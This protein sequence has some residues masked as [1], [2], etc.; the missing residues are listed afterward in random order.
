VARLNQTFNLIAD[1]TF[2]PRPN[3]KV[4]AGPSGLH[5][6]YRR[7]GLNVLC[8]EIRVPPT[9]WAVAPRQISIALTNACDLACSYCYAPKH[10]AALDVV[11]L[12]SWLRELDASGCLA[13]GFGGGEPTLH[14]HFIE[15]CQY[16][17]QHTAL[18]VTFTTHAHRIDEALADRLRESVHFVRVSMDGV[19]A[20]YELLRGRSFATLRTRFKIIQTFARFGINFVVNAATIRDLD[21]AIR[22]ATDV[23]ASEFLLLPEQPVHGQGGID[24]VTLRNLHEWVSKYRGEVPLTISE[25]GSEGMPIV[26]ASADGTGLR[27]YA[28]IDADSILRRSS[29]S[30]RGVRIGPGGVIGALHLLRA[31]EE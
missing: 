28:H 16:V 5:L 17:A 30:S 29:Y 13:V 18:A 8:D 1:T 2:A 11:P 22:M 26:P 23:G 10:R 25:A 31:Q 15:L 6:F 21:T 20:N 9:L 12:A 4:R 19:G 3:L 14:R 24:P 7:T 27:A